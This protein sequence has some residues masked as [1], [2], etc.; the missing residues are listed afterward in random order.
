[1]TTPGNLEETIKNAAG[2][3]RERLMFRLLLINKWFLI[4]TA[5]A[6]EWI[7]SNSPFRQYVYNAILPT[8]LYTAFSL[9]LIIL[10]WM[11]YRRLNQVNQDTYYVQVKRYLTIILFAIDAVFVFYQFIVPNVGN[12]LWL[13]FFR[14]L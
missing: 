13:L 4:P 14:E 7:L 1:M 10:L 3:E 11:C 5:V 6:Y 9:I 12:T 8:I 2:E